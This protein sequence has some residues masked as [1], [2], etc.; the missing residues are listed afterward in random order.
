MKIL[1][2]R[3]H[4]RGIALMV[5]LLITTFLIMLTGALI[6]TQ[7]GSFALMRV[8]D[9]RRDARLACRGLYDFCLYQ[10]EHNRNWGKGGFVDVAEVHGTRSQDQALGD[11]TERFKIE[12]VDGNAFMGKLTD[13]NLAFEIRVTNALTS[14]SAIDAPE[15]LAAQPEQVVL[16]ISVGE[17]RGDEFVSMQ[18]ATSV[19]ELAPLFDASILSRGDIEIDADELFFSS[20]DKSRNEVRTEGAANLPGL[21]TGDTRFLDF[22]PA[23]L[24]ESV[25]SGAARFDGIGLLHAGG[26]VKDRGVVLDAEQASL[27]QRRSGGRIIS[28]GARRVDIYNLKPENIPQPPASELKHDIVVP[29]GEFRFDQIRATV[30]VEETGNS[31]GVPKGDPLLGIGV[32]EG[33]RT[34]TEERWIDVCAYYD[35]PGSEEPLKIM[36]GDIDRTSR[37]IT[38]GFSRKIK[39]VVVHSK[40]GGDIPVDIGK[41]FYLNSDYDGSKPAAGGRV[42]REHGIRSEKNG[43]GGPVVIDLESHSLSVAPNTRV[44]PKSRPQNSP[45]PKS[46]FE[47]TSAGGL[48]PVFNLGS[49]QND[50]IFEADGDITI[51]SGVTKGLGTLISKG[52]SVTLEPT[53]QELHWELEK[54][55]RG[56]SRWVL[57]KGIK[58]KANDRYKGL[59]VYADKDVNIRNTGKADWTFRG[60]VY[61]NGKFN[62]DM[63]G[64]TAKFFG[65]VIARAQGTGDEAGF[66]VTN[67]DR[68]GFIYD[69]EYLKTLTRELPNNWTRVQPIVWNSSD[70]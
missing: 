55:H 51:G 8:S 40:F 27:A 10:I 70:S 34:Y 69:P 28:E 21:R 4:S 53:P 54:D 67:G 17:K 38:G 47:I 7:S 25:D 23:L 36:R 64:E 57:R 16:A 2:L 44:K 39:D 68:L 20:K 41:R 62:F 56:I 13:E 33:P 18:K 29:P 26:K 65:S 14:S 22:D 49:E 59:V 30:T 9:R 50:V 58:V 24:R 43:G 15:G 6:K 3:P 12:A 46:S 37:T 48:K 45:L 5:A 11:I 32:D 42:A 35:P 66:S 52:G 60:F 63:G 1:R 19:L 31:L 61:A